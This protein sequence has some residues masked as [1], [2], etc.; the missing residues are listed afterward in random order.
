[1]PAMLMGTYS[2]MA[3]ENFKFGTKSV[4]HRVDIYAVGILLY[5][6]LARK[7]LL[8]FKKEKD[9]F[10]FANSAAKI[11][12]PNIPGVPA[13]VVK[14]LEKAIAKDPDER[15]Q[16]CAEALKEANHVMMEII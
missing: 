16:S 4:D 1:M 14:F 3:P 9:V 6:L 13:A 2:Y 5:Y 11:N 7:P 15:F 12:I 8:T 10:E